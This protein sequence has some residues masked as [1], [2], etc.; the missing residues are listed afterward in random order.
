MRMENVLKSL[1]YHTIFRKLSWIQKTSAA[2]QNKLE[3]IL[4]SPVLSMNRPKT[5]NHNCHFPGQSIN[6]NVNQW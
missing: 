4:S 6:V 2:T 5:F 1:K 3:S